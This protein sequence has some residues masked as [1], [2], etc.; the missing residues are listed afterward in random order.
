MSITSQMKL[1]KLDRAHEFREVSFKTEYRTETNQES[2]LFQNFTIF[3][4]WNI[5]GRAPV[6]FT[7]Y[8]K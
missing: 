1:V 4:K 3:L 8:L 5:E 2:P 7:D 6:S